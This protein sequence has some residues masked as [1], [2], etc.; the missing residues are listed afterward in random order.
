MR[1]MQQVVKIWV[2][3]FI[4]ST[5]YSQ[6]MSDLKEAQYHLKSTREYIR[7]LFYYQSRES[8]IR[9]TT[10]MNSREHQ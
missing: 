3:C 1:S 8:I 5:G 9:I 4:Q 6:A 10:T 2:P 7:G